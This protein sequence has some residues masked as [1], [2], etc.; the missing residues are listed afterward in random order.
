ML[1]WI[2]N[3]SGVLCIAPFCLSTAMAIYY[4]L[5][6]GK[7]GAPYALQVAMYMSAA[8]LFAIVLTRL[9][10]SYVKK[11]LPSDLQGKPW[12]EMSEEEFRRCKGFGI[13]GLLLGTSGVIVVSLVLGFIL[14]VAITF[15][16]SDV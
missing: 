4:T 3:H 14:P 8:G 16:K 15:I 1:T 9:P 2:R 7:G 10:Y 11:N 6:A 13:A 12:V 5:M